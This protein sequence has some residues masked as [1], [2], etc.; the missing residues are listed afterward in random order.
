MRHVL[1]CSLV[2]ALFRFCHCSCHWLLSSPQ[3]TLH[4][5]WNFSSGLP[6]ISFLLSSPTLWRPSSFV[7]LQPADILLLRV[8]IS[9]HIVHTHEYEPTKSETYQVKHWDTGLLP[10]KSLEFRRENRQT[11]Y[12][13]T[14]WDVLRKR[15]VESRDEAGFLCRLA[16]PVFQFYSTIESS[17]SKALDAGE[18]EHSS[19]RLTMKRPCRVIIITSLCCVSGLESVKCVYILLSAYILI[20][21]LFFLT[22]TL[23][24]TACVISTFGGPFPS[25]T[26]RLPMSLRP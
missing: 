4:Y 13:N 23:E 19:Q 6:W 26:D 9:I 22:P 17:M 10:S 14:V 8:P 12:N 21:S 18:H 25:N 20:F 15:K 11:N 24:V 1:P 16:L 3:H 2:R 5:R 7:F